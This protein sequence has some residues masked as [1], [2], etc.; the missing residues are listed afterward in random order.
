MSF[1]NQLPNSDSSLIYC[2]SG[3]ITGRGIYDISALC[4]ENER[5]QQL[6]GDAIS[7]VGSLA[8]ISVSEWEIRECLYNGTLICIKLIRV[9]GVQLYKLEIGNRKSEI[10]VLYSYSRLIHDLYKKQLLL[11]RK[12]PAQIAIL[13]KNCLYMISNKIIK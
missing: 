7:P 8:C 9:M 6:H 12:I 13:N 4:S 11:N 5:V 2:I 10:G 3:I 1:W